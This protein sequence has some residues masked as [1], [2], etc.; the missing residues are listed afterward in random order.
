MNNQPNKKQEAVGHA[1]AGIIG[2]VL[3]F[4]TTGGKLEKAFVGG[5]VSVIAHAVLDRP[6][7]ITS[8]V[9][10]RSFRAF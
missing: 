2:T 1:V 6:S 8:Q 9:T 5:V 7:P 10:R 3:G 4:V